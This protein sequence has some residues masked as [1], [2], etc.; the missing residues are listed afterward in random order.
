M[1]PPRP[2]GASHI[3]HFMPVFYTSRWVTPPGG[4]LLEYS[5]PYP[6][7]IVAKPV[8]PKATGFVDK[9]NI[10]E[11]LPP[12]DARQLEEAFFSPLD[13]SAAKVLERIE[14]GW[15]NGGKAQWTSKDRSE[16]SRFV[17]SMMF[18][19]PEELESAK[20]GF[21]EDWKT[22]TPEVRA[23]F[24]AA[25]DFPG[26][27][28][29]V[30]EFLAS[31]APE[32]IRA[33]ALRMVRKVM[34]DSRAIGE[35]LNNAH[36]RFVVLPEACFDLVTGDRPV[37]NTDGL[38]VKNAYLTMP[39]GPRRLFVASQSAAVADKVSRTRL[40]DLAKTTNKGC[41]RRAYRYVYAKDKTHD[42][43]I[44]KHFGKD[45]PLTWMEQMRAVRARAKAS[46]DYPFPDP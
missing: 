6:G 27:P 22:V 24:E 13:D 1:G 17:M 44:R 3:H 37:M 31:Q 38:G 12:D 45:R 25:G 30:E 14:S 23:A 29:S 8:G 33:D 36:W 7:K 5:E 21:A 15:G 46:G 10:L 2:Q 34:L 18:R 35:R 19:H 42:E 9:L 28:A 16:W 20:A 32:R 26:K 43:F 40:P 41:V 4:K 11:D 39:I